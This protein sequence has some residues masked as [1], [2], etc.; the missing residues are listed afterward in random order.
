ML[1]LSNLPLKPLLQ[2]SHLLKLLRKLSRRKLQL[3][4]SQQQRKHQRLKNQS[5]KHLQKPLQLME[6]PLKLKSNLD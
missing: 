4:R 5:L 3:K 1:R 2:R 6:L